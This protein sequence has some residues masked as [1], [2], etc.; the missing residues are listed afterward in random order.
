[1]LDQRPR[2]LVVHRQ[3]SG[4]G[5]LVV[6]VI[7]PTATLCAVLRMIDAN[8]LRVFRAPGEFC[9]AVIARPSELVLDLVKET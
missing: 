9:A 2:L 1:M 8:E 5:L 6:V 4:H 7:L 3:A